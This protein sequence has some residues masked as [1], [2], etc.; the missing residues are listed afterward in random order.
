MCPDVQCIVPPESAVRPTAV[1]FF[2]APWSKLYQVGW[3]VWSMYLKHT[4]RSPFLK[5]LCLSLHVMGLPSLL[6]LPE[7]ATHQ[8]V[9]ITIK[10]V[11]DLLFR[12]SLCQVHWWTLLFSSMV[13][14]S[15]LIHRQK[16]SI[17][18]FPSCSNG[19][20]SG[21]LCKHFEVSP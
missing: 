14:A 13:L 4:R 17:K 16:H 7:Y 11:I 21:C 9:L 8:Q 3:G 6:L 18:M 20:P 10:S 1:C 2:P 5:S 15:L 12:A 19:D